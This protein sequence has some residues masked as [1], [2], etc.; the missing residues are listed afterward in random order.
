[1]SS[2]I[3]IR[4]ASDLHEILVFEKLRKC[5]DHDRI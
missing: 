2:Y 5:F 4:L 1:M 3:E